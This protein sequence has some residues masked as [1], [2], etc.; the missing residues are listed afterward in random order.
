[1]A[2]PR[3]MAL[4]HVL[5]PPSPTAAPRAP[6][7]LRAKLAGPF[8]PPPLRALIAGTLGLV[9]R[10]LAVP[11]DPASEGPDAETR[12][13]SRVEPFL[14]PLAVRLPDEEPVV[15]RRIDPALG[16]A[17]SAARPGLVPLSAELDR[18]MDAA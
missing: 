5:P 3:D 4:S 9:R 18:A 7:L 6:A 10:P 11:P 16:L 15:R 14:V 2:Q 12:L 8:G 17:I 13:A 1:M